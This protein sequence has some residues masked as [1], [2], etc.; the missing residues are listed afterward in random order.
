MRLIPALNV[1]GAEA[2]E[3]LTILEEAIRHEAR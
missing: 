1:S 2:D 3:G